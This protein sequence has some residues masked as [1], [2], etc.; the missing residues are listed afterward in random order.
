MAVRGGACEGGGGLAGA[1]S[2]PL[3]RGDPDVR[4]RLLLDHFLYFMVDLLEAVP[5]HDGCGHIDVPVRGGVTMKSDKNFPE[6]FM[7][8]PEKHSRKSCSSLRA[9]S[10]PFLACS[11]V[12]R[13]L[14]SLSAS[15]QNLY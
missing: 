15:D 6:N 14:I 8:L 1:A 5:F 10:I 3:P 7:L 13:V 9:R 12:R 2:Q 4:P 11:S